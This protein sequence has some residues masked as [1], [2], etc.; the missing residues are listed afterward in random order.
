MVANLFEQTVKVAST[1]DDV[2]F[3]L[4]G[5]S[6]PDDRLILEVDTVTAGSQYVIR[7]KPNKMSL[8]ES[9]N[10]SGEVKVLTDHSELPELTFRYNIIF[11]RR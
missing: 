5:V 9:R 7:S 10:V 3:G 6:D 11:P 8:K 1:K 2:K 4:L